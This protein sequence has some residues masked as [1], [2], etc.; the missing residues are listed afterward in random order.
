MATSFHRRNASRTK[1]DA[2]SGTALTLK[3]IILLSGPVSTCPIESHRVGDAKG[4]H[5]VRAVSDPTRWNCGTMRTAGAAL[6]WARCA[7]R[8]GWRASPGAWELGVRPRQQSG[9]LLE[10]FAQ[11]I[12]RE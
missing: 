6:R 7:A 9:N 12:G 3:E 5:V 8:N 11:P 2:P 1:L 4:E 10:I